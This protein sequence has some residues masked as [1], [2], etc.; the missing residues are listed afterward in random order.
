MQRNS[1]L[2]KFVWCKR[3]DDFIETGINIRHD[4]GLKIYPWGHSLGC[5]SGDDDC[6]FL[7]IELQ[8]CR[9]FRH[10]LPLEIVSHRKI[11]L[12]LLATAVERLFQSDA[13]HN[14]SI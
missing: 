13:E 1:R 14:R 9:L 10:L 5:A 3:G 4:G 11:R 8:F 6:D 12:E 7:T 2:Q